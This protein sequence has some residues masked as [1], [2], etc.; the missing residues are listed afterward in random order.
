MIHVYGTSHVS[1]ESLD[2]IDE[3][4][5]EHDPDLVALELDL[6]RLNA[7][8]TDETQRGGTLLMRML[9]K[10][11]DVIGSKT[12]LMPGREMLYAY[13]RAVAED[14]EIALID[15]DIRV[16]TQRLN[17][18]GR[19]EKVRAALSI[20]GG[21]VLPGRMNLAAI[22]GEEDIEI[23]A[24][25]LETHFPGFHRVLLEERNQ[26]MISALK[27]LQEEDPDTQIVALVGAAH[28]KSL[29]D[30]L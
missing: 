9:K 29:E 4:F 2:V 16:T 26:V 27:H 30:A 14:R 11:Q 12:G 18:L 23:M 8:L 3:A 5:E 15:Q 22:P 7:L 10:F 6:L 28:R 25:E 1:Q 21:L 24:D 20:I 13:R 17:S 19:K